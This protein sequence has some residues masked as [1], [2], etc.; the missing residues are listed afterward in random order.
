MEI[1]DYLC[2]TLTIL[3]LTWGSLLSYNFFTSLQNLN[4]KLSNSTNEEAKE[5]IEHKMAE[6]KKKEEEE[7]KSAASASKTKGI[8]KIYTLFKF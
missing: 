6:L 7:R 2:E 4:E 1:V 5:H 3:K 8:D